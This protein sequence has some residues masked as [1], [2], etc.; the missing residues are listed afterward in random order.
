MRVVN[1]KRVLH[2]KQVEVGVASISHDLTAHS[3]QAEQEQVSRERERYR[4]LSEYR[5]R[6]GSDNDNTDQS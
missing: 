1:Q 5:R 2:V 4:R 6:K 3:L